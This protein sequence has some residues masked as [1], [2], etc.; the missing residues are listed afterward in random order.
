M[1]DIEE[2]IARLERAGCT[3]IVREA[4]GQ[5]RFKR[6]VR[7]V[8]AGVAYRIDWW[9]NV[10][11]LSVG[12]YANYIPF[13]DMQEDTCWPSYRKG[14]RFRNGG[15]EVSYDVAYVA[16]TQLDWQLEKL[17]KRVIA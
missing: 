16:I 4:I 6:I 14:L 11:Y 2:L 13:T 17:K 1:L 7:F 9:I 8:A 10:S 5:E 12:D 3:D 15:G